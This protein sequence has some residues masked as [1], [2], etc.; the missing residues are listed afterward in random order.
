MEI[1]KSQ[2]QEKRALPPET[3]R[4]P[5]MNA[6]KRSQTPSDPLAIQQ[7]NFCFE[8]PKVRRGNVLCLASLSAGN[9]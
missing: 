7:P 1:V 9:K 2:S 5:K 3:R 4:H 6:A 8:L